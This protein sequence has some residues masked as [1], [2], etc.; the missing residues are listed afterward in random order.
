MKMK[1]QDLQFLVARHNGALGSSGTGSGSGCDG[2]TVH[3]CFADPTTA[4]I[5]E[6]TT[7]ESPS[8][9]KLVAGRCEFAIGLEG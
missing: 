1:K 5:R 7:E 2:T 4:Q 6:A 9:Y 8:G 3:C